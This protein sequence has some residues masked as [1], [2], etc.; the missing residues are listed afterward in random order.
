MNLS[1]K[2]TRENG[3]FHIDDLKYA[4]TDFYIKALNAR[5]IESESY[6]YNKVFRPSNQSAWT[7]TR[8]SYYA[9][10]QSS[11]VYIEDESSSC[12]NLSIIPLTELELLI[13]DIC[14]S[15]LTETEIKVLAFYII[16]SSIDAE[17]NSSVLTFHINQLI[18]SSIELKEDLNIDFLIEY[19]GTEYKY[20]TSRNSLRSKMI[21]ILRPV[22]TEVTQYGGE[23]QLLC[24]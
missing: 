11:E 13:D 8:R 21:D 3:Y 4:K 6:Y 12:F 16:K 1:P 20:R 22:Q 24:C 2:R 23:C 7:D 18:L 15:S 10:I 9:H 14:N 19:C 17:F 5:D